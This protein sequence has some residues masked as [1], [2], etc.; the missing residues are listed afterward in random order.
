MSS[1][2]TLMLAGLNGMNPLGFLA[3]LGTVRIARLFSVNVRL[4]W[5]RSSAAWR[6][7]LVDTVSDPDRFLDALEQA[8]RTLSLEPF[9]LDKRLPFDAKTYRK[10]ALIAQS[11]ASAH[12]RR[13][14]DFITAFGSDALIDE[15]GNFQDTLFR[16][17]R[18]GDSKGQGFLYYALQTSSTTT[19]DHLRN[20]LFR[21]WNYAD[22]SPSF[23]WDPIEDQRYA[24]RW[25]DPST[26]R[27]GTM[28]GANRMALEA[29]PLFPAIPRRA[30]LA[31]T[32]F[33]VNG[34]RQ[35]C[36]T[37]PIWEVPL[38]EEVIRSLL[39][40]SD[41][42]A[43]KIDRTTLAAQGIVDVFRSIRF[44][45]NQYYKNLAPANPA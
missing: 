8:L 9:K 37:W 29:L 33:S 45:P 38:A 7:N 22:K 24:M 26:N 31:T 27:L 40:L 35:T 21:P 28:Q 5:E 6:P 43:E 32:A 3:A 39:T 23:R 20:A 19:K 12:E 14:A 25:D 16:M 18:T 2:P 1:L 36:F 13:L 11:K 4:R 42:R 41:L 17:V 10:H 30:S 34:Q 15:N 44:A